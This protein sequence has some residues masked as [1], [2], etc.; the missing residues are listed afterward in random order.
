M[1]GELTD[2]DEFDVFNDGGGDPFGDEPESGREASTQIVGDTIT[3]LQK[4]L[5]TINYKVSEMCLKTLVEQ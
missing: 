2:F 4:S 1:G 5:Q 3:G